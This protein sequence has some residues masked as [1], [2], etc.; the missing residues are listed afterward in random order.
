MKYK[1]NKEHGIE[2]GMRIPNVGIIFHSMFV[3]LSLAIAGDEKPIRRYF[4]LLNFRRSG[5]REPSAMVQMMSKTCRS[6]G[7]LI[8]LQAIEIGHVY[9]PGLRVALVTTGY[10]DGFC[11]G[12]LINNSLVEIISSPEFKTDD[13]R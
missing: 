3:A 12:I 7:P 4:L 10:F 11:N 5:L 6:Y 8:I 13:R 1:S 2:D 9:M